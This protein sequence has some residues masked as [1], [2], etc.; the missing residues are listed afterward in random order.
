VIPWLTLRGMRADVPAWLG[1][2]PHSSANQPQTME[3][4]H[5]VAVAIVVTAIA[6]LGMVVL[7][8]AGTPARSACGTG[9][10]CYTH[11]VP[12]PGGQC[13]RYRAGVYRTWRW[14]VMTCQR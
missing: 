13:R 8:C 9:P 7:T 2:D 11:G 1:M 12:G 4:A 5:T 3:T 6:A 14:Q 10:L